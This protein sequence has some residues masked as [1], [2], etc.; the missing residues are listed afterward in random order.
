MQESGNEYYI[1]TPTDSFM[2]E[3][4]VIA[5]EPTKVTIYP[6]GSLT[7]QGKKYGKNR[8]L[9]FDI[10][11][12]DVVQ[13]QSLDNLTGSR[14]VATKP[15][16]VLSGHT[17]SL[18]FTKCNHVY[19]QLQPTFIWGTTFFIPPVSFQTEYNLVYVMAATPNTAVTYQVGSQTKN[20]NLAPGDVIEIELDPEAPIFINSTEGIQVMYYLTGGHSQHIDYDTVLLTVPD[21]LSFCTSFKA[22]GLSDFINDASLVAKTSDLQD[23]TVDKKALKDVT[24]KAIQGTEYSYGEYPI[25]DSQSYVFES[26]KS[27]FSLSILAIAEL[28]SYGETAVC[29]GGKSFWVLFKTIYV[30]AGRTGLR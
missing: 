29:L 15:V 13:F 14:V 9:I 17:C 26:S 22:T 8:K 24:W 18:K 11:P 5:K 16:V 25:S 12:Y 19:E 23:L 2:K 20:L 4:A 21:V 28:N 7:F 6:T 3:F 27:S 10:N 30:Y 1:F